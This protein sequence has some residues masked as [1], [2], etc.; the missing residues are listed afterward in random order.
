MPI[1]VCVGL[2]TLTVEIIAGGLVRSILSPGEILDH[3]RLTKFFEL[4]LQ[5]AA[6][7]TVISR[8]L[9]RVFTKIW[10]RLILLFLGAIRFDVKR[11]SSSA[12][13]CV[14]LQTALQPSIRC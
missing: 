8:P 14:V 4:P 12:R 6:G 1:L 2:Y 5:S 7:L 11:S 3:R 9:H 13:G 10:T